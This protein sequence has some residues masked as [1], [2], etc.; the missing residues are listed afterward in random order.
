[1]LKFS[2]THEFISRG[3]KIL[4]L[5]LMS[6]GTLAE[7]PPDNIPDNIALPDEPSVMLLL[8]H[9]KYLLGTGSDKW[10]YASEK[11]GTEPQNVFLYDDKAL[12]LLNEGSQPTILSGKTVTALRKKLFMN[13]DPPGQHKATVLM[14]KTFMKDYPVFKLEDDEILD[15]NIFSYE[16]DAD[17]TLY[18]I[19]WALRFALSRGEMETVARL[20][21]WLNSS[22]SD[23]STNPAFMVKIY[24][25]LLGLPE[26]DAIEELEELSF[27][28]NELNRM[29]IQNASPLVVY[30]PASG[31]LILGRFG[32][33]R[34]TMFFVWVYLNHELWHELRLV[35]RL[36]VHEII[37]AVWG[38]ID[39]QQAMTERAKYKGADITE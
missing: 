36:P 23:I 34:S 19:Y 16:L 9:N 4:L 29:I 37:N 15:E 3:E 10:I 17:Y 12:S 27:S 33:N 7:L 24:F 28:R 18:R 20:K 39:I 6:N 8:P 11:P 5:E 21:A 25:S 22:W 2:D 32:R 38:E 30:N 31:W 13:T 14:M 1:M 35:R 26:K